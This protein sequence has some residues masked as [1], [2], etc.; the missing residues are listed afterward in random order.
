MLAGL[1]DV[2][3]REKGYH[4]A[5]DLHLVIEG[6]LKK[7]VDYDWE[8]AD[9]ARKKSEQSRDIGE[10]LQTPALSIKPA[11]REISCLVF[12][13]FKEELEAISHIAEAWCR[14]CHEEREVFNN[15]SVV[16]I[17][18]AIDPDKKRIYI[19]ARLRNI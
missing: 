17:G 16:G 14:R 18:V 10:I 1:I 7:R 19:T 12:Y 11:E 15:Y 8:L 4:L 13:T 9:S 5:H 3:L 6:F 2:D